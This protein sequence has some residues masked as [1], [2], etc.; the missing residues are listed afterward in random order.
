MDDKQLDGML[1]KLISLS[2]SLDYLQTKL[3]LHKEEV[4]SIIDSIVQNNS[5][6]DE[7]DMTYGIISIAEAKTMEPFQI[8]DKLINYVTQAGTKAELEMLGRSSIML[9]ESPMGILWRRKVESFVAKAGKNSSKFADV[10]NLYRRQPK[11]F[12]GLLYS[13]ISDAAKWEMSFEFQQVMKDKRYEAVFG[14]APLTEVDQI[15]RHYL[16]VLEIIRFSTLDPFESGA[17]VNASMINDRSIKTWISPRSVF[18]GMRMTKAN[19]PK[20][21]KLELFNQYLAKRMESSTPIEVAK[22]SLAQRQEVDLKEAAVNKAKLAATKI[23]KQSELREIA[24]TLVFGNR[25][26]DSKTDQILLPTY[27]KKMAAIQTGMYYIAKVKYRKDDGKLT[28]THRIIKVEEVNRE[29]GAVK[30]Q[31]LTGSGLIERD[32]YQ[33]VNIPEW[34]ALNAVRYTRKRQDVFDL[35]SLMVMKFGKDIE[36]SIYTHPESRK[37][38]KEVYEN[39]NINV[40][41]PLSKEGR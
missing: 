41:Q 9:F 3:T 36:Q 35:D 30:F 11:T 10:E 19:P 24:G 2:D 14:P 22:S 31:A 32:V 29:R 34:I 13:N 23:P 40:E 5:K 7:D 16:L 17:V 33:E 37:Y 1:K 18:K 4:H 15:R 20:S 28:A 21:V 26:L 6:Y 25:K 12:S 8:C 38:L 27:A 39:L